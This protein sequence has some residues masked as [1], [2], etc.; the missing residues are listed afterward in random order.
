MLVSLDK[1]ME[2]N[3]TNENKWEHSHIKDYIEVY[4]EW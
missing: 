4:I 1:H 3:E 2:I